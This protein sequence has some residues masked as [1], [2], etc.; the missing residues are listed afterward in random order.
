MTCFVSRRT[1]GI[2]NGSDPPFLAHPPTLWNS[3]DSRNASFFGFVPFALVPRMPSLEHRNSRT[4][5]AKERA[6]IKVRSQS[7]KKQ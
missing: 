5:L 6:G 1:N 3:W 7:R 2:G 4:L